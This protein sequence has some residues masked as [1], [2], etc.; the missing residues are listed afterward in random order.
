MC[1]NLVAR[2]QWCRKKPAAITYIPGAQDNLKVVEEEYT[3]KMHFLLWRFIASRSSWSMQCAHLN[4]IVQL[5]MHAVFATTINRGTLAISRGTRTSGHAT[6][7]KKCI[8]VEQQ[9]DKRICL[10]PS[11]RSFFC[12][13]GYK[14]KLTSSFYSVFFLCQE[15]N[16][17]P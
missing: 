10:R 2:I 3:W 13:R 5:T 6:T 9:R 17:S 15:E 4:C 14:Q 7:T 16:I 1:I 11:K 8:S 12:P